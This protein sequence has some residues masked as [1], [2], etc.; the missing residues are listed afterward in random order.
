M[1]IQTALKTLVEGQDL[2]QD[3][4]QVV[5][6]QIMTGECAESQIGAFLMALRIKGESVAEITGAAM[7]MRELSTKVT[8]DAEYLVDTCGTGGSGQ[9]LFNVST[10][11]AFVAA[12]A[13]ASV[14]KHGNRAVSSNFGSA[15]LLEA[16]G[17]NL[18]VSPE[19]IGR[20]IETV[21]VGFMFAQAHH[22]AMRHAIGVRKALG[23]RTIFNV[24]GPLTNPAGVKRQVM[25]VFDASLCEPLANALKALGS[26]HVMVVH[27]ADGLDEFS[28]ADSTFVAELKDGEIRTYDVTPE[29]VG[30]KSQNLESLKAGDAE[31][32]LAMIKALLSGDREGHLDAAADMLVLNAGAAIYVSGVA[33]SLTEGVRMAEDAL[34]SGLAGEKLV[35]FAEFTQSAIDE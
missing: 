20:A 6:R 35:Q 1:N 11:S 12:A 21:G 8:V 4:M 10:A 27:S 16:A 3:D 2:S 33:S 15:D 29:S 19:A 17:V 5:M 34:A 28:L 32:S 22:S 26:E 31:T 24:L 30:L 9:K 14:A 25:G 18:G 7:I 13:G 23:M